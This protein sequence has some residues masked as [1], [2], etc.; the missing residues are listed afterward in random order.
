MQGHGGFALGE[1]IEQRVGVVCLVANQSLWISLL[2]QRLCA[3]QI[4]GLPGVSIKSTGLPRAS[5][6]AWPP[7][8]T[9]DSPVG[10][11]LHPFAY[12]EKIRA[13]PGRQR[14]EFG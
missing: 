5:T 2:K 8:I 11:R 3:S 7:S 6:R 4:V 1:R 10:K 9:C 14:D 13:R 12:M